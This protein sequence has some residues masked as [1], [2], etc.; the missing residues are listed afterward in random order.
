[1]A[2]LDSVG[3]DLDSSLVSHLVQGSLRNSR[4]RG[5]DL[6]AAYTVA[7]EA[8]GDLYPDQRFATAAFGHLDLGSGRFRWISAGHPAPLVV[9][10]TDVAGEAPTVPTT[11][12]G[13]RHTNAPDVNEVVLD[14]GD[15]VVRYTDGVTEGGVRGGERFGLDRFVDVLGRILVE[16]LPPAEVLRRLVAEVLEHSAHE[17]H[18]DMG[19]VLVQRRDGEA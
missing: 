7:D 2:I 10:G 5:L 3:H 16:G 6:P 11:P 4:R 18:D 12:I 17:L 13:L 9:R 1:V 8:L 14:R 15:A 19:I